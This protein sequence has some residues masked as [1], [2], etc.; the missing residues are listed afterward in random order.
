MDTPRA[1]RIG[2]FV[3]AGLTLFAVGLFLIGDRRLLFERHYEL[4]TSFFRVPGLEVGTKV[5]VAGMDAGEVTAIDIPPTPSTPF[6]V[7]MRI[8]QD[9]APLV[10]TDSTAQIQVDGIVGNMFVQVG[11]GT[12]GAPEAPA[13]SRIPGA[14]PVEF[15]DVLDRAAETLEAFRG[16]VDEIGSRVTVT[17]EEINGT[18]ASVNDVVDTVGK[19]A[20][21]VTAS[22]K[23]SMS[24]VEGI[25]DETRTVV[26]SVRAG[27]GT[28][29]KLLTDESLYQE[30]RQTAERAAKTA[31][32]IRQTSESARDAVDRLFAP[33]G[34]TDGVLAELRGAA[35]AAEEVLSDLAENTE[36]I[37]RNV[38]VRGFFQRRGFFDI[39]ALTPVEYRRFAG[40]EEKRTALRIWI[41]ADALFGRNAAGQET[42]TPEGR[43]R[44]D[45]AMGTFLQYRRDSP[46]IV[47]GYATG[48][49]TSAQFLESDA[50][51]RVVRDHLVRR[52][53]RDASITGAIGLAEDAVGSP[54]GDGRWDG[55]A[56]TL[57]VS[58]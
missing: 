9:L 18:I 16:Q 47:E 34:P 3:L 39:D 23:R 52:F 17:L 33:G 11:R 13:G 53:R 36:A 26:T 35:A 6:I 44:L 5:R 25:L 37:K 58:K 10:R 32:N 20:A 51:A 40:D 4:E 54:S 48:P 41:G 50:R 55:V 15:A 42:L 22:V 14:E 28:V 21:D 45:L 31:E 24:S 57:L 30:M 43:S 29:G 12:D 1:A 2:A 7:R 38:L 27:E 19:G 56:L 46:L 8:R 49:T